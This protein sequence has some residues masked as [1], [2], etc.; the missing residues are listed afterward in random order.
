MNFGQAIEALKEGKKISR[1]A[2]EKEGLYVFMM[3]EKDI[4]EQAKG[5]LDKLTEEER[6]TFITDHIV[7]A[8]PD[9]SLEGFRPLPSDMLSEDWIIVE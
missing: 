3:K 8:S 1:E 5:V 7:I 9:L 4:S 6:K 2:W